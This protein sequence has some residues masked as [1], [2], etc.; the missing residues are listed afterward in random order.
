[1]TPP[2]TPQNSLC[3]PFIIETRTVLARD[4]LDSKPSGKGPRL[5]SRLRSGSRASPSGAVLRSL[6]GTPL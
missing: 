2:H 4:D 5:P 3:L 1:M 6:L